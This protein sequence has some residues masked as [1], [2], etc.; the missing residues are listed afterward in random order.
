MQVLYCLLSAFKVSRMQI[1]I[2]R[3]KTVYIAP[4]GRFLHVLNSAIDMYIC[5]YIHIYTYIYIYMY[6]LPYMLISDFSVTYRY[7][8]FIQMLLRVRCTMLHIYVYM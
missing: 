7:Y 4:P 2:V 8:L 6:V 5:T 1:Q 3:N